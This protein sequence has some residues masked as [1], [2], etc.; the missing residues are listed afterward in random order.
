[1]L[2]RV[3]IFEYK[4]S[5]RHT[6][7]YPDLVAR[8]VLILEGLGEPLRDFEVANGLPERDWITEY[9]FFQQGAS[10]RICPLFGCAHTPA[11][12]SSP[13]PLVHSTRAPAG[14][15]FV[16]LFCFNK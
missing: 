10:G 15:L 5:Q 16:V 14:C 1:M 4:L 2:V 6:L 11:P 8:R 13:L 12:R 9:L 7:A 3:Q